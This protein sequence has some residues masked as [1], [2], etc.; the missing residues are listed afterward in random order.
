M[1]A[2]APA[3]DRALWLDQFHAFSFTHLFTLVA[4][5][6]VI[7]CAVVIGVRMRDSGRGRTA[8]RAMAA[9]G[10]LAWVV[11]ASWW[12]SPA[13][14][15]WGNSLPLQLC[16]LAGLVAPIAIWTRNRA[17]RALLY[18]WGIGLCTQGLVTPIAREG[19][20]HAA[21]WMAWINH[22]AIAMLAVYD[23]VVGRFRPGWRDLRLA[24][25]TT[26]VYA[27]CMFGL[28]AAFDWNY[29]Y[30]GR[31]KPGAPTIL[32]SLGA[33]PGR[34]VVIMALGAFAMTAILLPWLIWERLHRTGESRARAEIGV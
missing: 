11:V 15:T 20:A 34:V 12:L 22:G 26:T 8:D 18:F 30:V 9:I 25:I 5:G 23:L 19:P 31:S 6:V 28:D 17:A 10:A 3:T 2:P 14:F 29:G 32:D 24:L 33:W 21:F 4:L 27:L 16:D 13:R 1:T 7:A